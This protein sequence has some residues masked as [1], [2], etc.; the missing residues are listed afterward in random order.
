MNYE[1]FS[2]AFFFEYKKKLSSAILDDSQPYKS[3]KSTLL[4]SNYSLSF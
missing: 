4:L 2:Y 1:N 3:T